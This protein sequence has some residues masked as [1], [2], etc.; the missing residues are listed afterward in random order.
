MSCPRLFNGCCR[1][2]QVDTLFSVGKYQYRPRI[3]INR[4]V[5]KLMVVAV[6]CFIKHLL[7]FPQRGKKT[8]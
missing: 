1:V 2:L 7:I 4:K 3:N 8:W 6:F 5:L